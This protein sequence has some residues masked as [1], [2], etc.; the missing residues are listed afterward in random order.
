MKIKIISGLIMLCFIHKAALTQD[1]NE[2]IK[3]NAS[4][5]GY[6][7]DFGFKTCI[8]G[9][10]AIVGAWGDSI[11]ASG[12]NP[13][14]C[15]GSAYV[16]ERDISGNWNEGQ[17]IVASDR[18]EYD[19]FGY[20]VSISGNY[21]IVGANHEDED[22]SGGNTMSASGSSYI[23]E[24]DGYGNWHQ[25]Q[26]IVASDRAEIDNFGYSV[27]ISG[28]YAAVG[29]YM[30]DE[31]AS[32]GNTMS[33]SG[34]V[35]IF[36]RA[37]DGN[38]N[39]LQKIVSSDRDVGDKLGYSVCI[40]GNTIVVSTINE[41]EDASGEN[42]LDEA[43]S[44]YVF[45]RDGGGNWNEVQKIVAPDRAANDHFG[46]S[47]SISGN[48]AIIGAKNEDEDA[49][50]GNTLESAGS[51]YIFEPNGSEYW[52]KVQKIVAS[53]RAGLDY[54]GGSVSISGNYA[55]IG[56]IEEDEDA[57]GANTM[58]AS[59]SAY[60]F[61]SDAGGT[62]NEIQKIVASDRAADE[63]FG[64]SV[65]IS[66]NYAL[67]G[68]CY[69]GPP[70]FD[71]TGSAYIFESCIPGT[72][73][74]PDNILE[75]GDFET[76]ILSP[77]SVFIAD[78]LGVTANAVLIDGI[79]TLSGIT[80]SADPQPWYV[81]LN[82]ELSP[83][84]L[85]RLEKD[86]TYILTFDASA[87][88]ENRPCRISFE[89]SVDPWA[90]IM[91]ESIILGTETESYSLE[92]VMSSI[93]TDMQLSLQVGLETSPVTFDNVRLVKKVGG[94][95]TAIDQVNRNMIR[96]FPN[97]A[98]D[99]LHIITE[100][101]SIVKLY[102]SAGLLIKEDISVKSRVNFNVTGLPSGIYIIAVCKD[103]NLYFHKIAIQSAQ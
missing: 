32:G 72:D 1:F 60:I 30:E 46:C 43:G 86:S 22:A 100:N 91:N 21:A 70:G 99:Y 81:Q 103:N 40:S 54:F 84:Q 29:A 39:E 3:L 61:N 36:E 65:S 82:Q 94:S 80:L 75:N 23:F 73:P 93:F 88:T 42:T 8:S 79:C 74:D 53:D 83:A 15:A 48:Y 27:S 20:S 10:Y 90:N 97:P 102:N 37:E 24:R 98:S 69:F 51:A 59:G 78:Y 76:C 58:S 19:Y 18:A 63:Y 85:G 87:E 26:K 25:V 57:S 4:Q 89:Q 56:A 41:S 33:A 68:Q 96:L 47:V 34:S 11:D 6:L 9:N 71:F 77:W 66:G 55:I 16:F 67:I 49:S 52:N 13:L 92:F 31:D 38:W 7:N 62:W 17:K 50:G 64:V 35:Y 14:V 28:N 45:E 5:S 2:V 12:S 95:P 44:A 101:G